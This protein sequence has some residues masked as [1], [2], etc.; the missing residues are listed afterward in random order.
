MIV[1]EAQAPRRQRI[2]VRGG[3]APAPVAAEVAVADVVGNDHD[4]VWRGRAEGR[5]EGKNE[6]KEQTIHCARFGRR[7]VPR[8]RREQCG[9][10][11]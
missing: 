8:L 7:C 9:R 1:R 10:W 5:A 6:K 4:D 3:I 11:R 2:K